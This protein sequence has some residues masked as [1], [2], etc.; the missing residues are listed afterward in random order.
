M[1]FV[2]KP[3]CQVRF[4]T[5]SLLSMEFV[6]NLGPAIEFV[7]NSMPDR[8]HEDLCGRGDDPPV[9]GRNGGWR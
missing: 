3:E 2:T 8:F 9:A 4:V 5:L 6:K 1:D 7:T